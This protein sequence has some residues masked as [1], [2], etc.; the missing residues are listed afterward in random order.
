MTP[1][2]PYIPTPHEQ[3]QL[4][5]VARALEGEA[6][7]LN[8]QLSGADVPLPEPLA[9][10]IAALIQEA[11]AGHAVSI[12]PTEQDLSTFEAAHLLGVSRP[13]LI[14]HLLD[15]GK[16]PHHRVGTHR[17][18]ALGDVLAYQTEQARRRELAAEL[19]AEAQAMGLY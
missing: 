17:R 13:F 8:V 9:R 10:L 16:L 14:S 7:T 5:A 15:T 6:A 4:Q 1:T 3:A 12:V 2:A 18:V 11:A 19:T